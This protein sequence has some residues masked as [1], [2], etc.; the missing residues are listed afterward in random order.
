MGTSAASSPAVAG[1]R[2]SVSSMVRRLSSAS[3]RRAASIAFTVPRNRLTS[4]GGGTSC[5]LVPLESRGGERRQQR[6]DGRLS[7]LL[8][9][10]LRA[11]RYGEPET[12]SLAL[13]ILGAVRAAVGLHRGGDHGQPQPGARRVCVATASEWREERHRIL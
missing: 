8:G 6:V 3:A 4:C 11:V 1:P 5:P 12:R 2:D 13:A 9:R 10:L 7:T